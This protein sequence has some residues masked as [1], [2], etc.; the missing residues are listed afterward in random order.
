M[1]QPTTEATTAEKR[2]WLREHRPDLNVG[3]RGFLSA[4]AKAAYDAARAA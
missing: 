1:T 4:E 2:A 3:E